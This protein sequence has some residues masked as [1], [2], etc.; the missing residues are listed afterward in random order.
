MARPLAWADTTFSTALVNGANITPVNL[1]LNL[2]G[3]DTITAM[4]IVGH[5]YVTQQ[6]VDSALDGLYAVDLG[7]GV[8]AK[9]AFDAGV[10]PDPQTDGDVPARGWMWKDRLLA[11]RTQLSSTGDKLYVGE[12]RFDIRSAR[13]V[14]RG[15]MYI[16]AFLSTLNGTP[17]N[18][19]LVGHTRVLCAT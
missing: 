4:R 5:L 3:A 14:D 16:N 6:D 12:V 10:V 9:E 17:A 15:I 11:V 7:I 19:T 13:K 18:H 2:A 8:A 1:L